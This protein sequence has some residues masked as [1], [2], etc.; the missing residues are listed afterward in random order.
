MDHMK[1]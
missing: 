1:L